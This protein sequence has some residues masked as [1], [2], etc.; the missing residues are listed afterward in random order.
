M[1]GTSAL[2]V[3]TGGHVRLVEN[4]KT[5]ITKATRKAAIPSDLKH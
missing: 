2:Q 5:K 1:V 4:L 3:T